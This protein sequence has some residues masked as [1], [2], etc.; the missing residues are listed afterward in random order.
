MLQGRLLTQRSLSKK[1]RICTYNC[2]DDSTVFHTKTTTLAT[3][4]T[5]KDD[6]LVTKS[7]PPQRMGIL[8]RFFIGLLVLPFRPS[9]S[10]IPCTRTCLIPLTTRAAVALRFACM[11]PKKWDYSFRS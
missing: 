5:L 10:H 3:E 6:G 11:R 7:Y 2:E 9:K 4:R 8:M 1:I